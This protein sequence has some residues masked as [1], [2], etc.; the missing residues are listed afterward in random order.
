M[1]NFIFGMIVKA[2]QILYWHGF[3]EGLQKQVEIKDEVSGSINFM[4]ASAINSDTA[5]SMAE[6]TEDMKIRYF[7]ERKRM[8]K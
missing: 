3:G 8:L 2:R 5:L 4:K 6:I 7:V 1:Y